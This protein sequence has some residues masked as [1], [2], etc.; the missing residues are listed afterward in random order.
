MSNGTVKIVFLDSPYKIR[1]NRFGE[2]TLGAAGL[3]KKRGPVRGPRSSAMVLGWYCA[4]AHVDCARGQAKPQYVPT[5]FY[6][7]F[8]ATHILAIP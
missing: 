1:V 2:T 7:C 5:L 6:C 8:T 4:R 3:N